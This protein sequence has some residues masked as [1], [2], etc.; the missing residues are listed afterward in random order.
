MDDTK[1]WQIIFSV[2]EIFLTGVYQDHSTIQ[3]FL[4]TYIGLYFII[5]LLLH[6]KIDMNWCVSYKHNTSCMKSCTEKWDLALEYLFQ[7]ILQ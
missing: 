4:I 6:P 3:Q 5:Y 2:D 1:K 7:M